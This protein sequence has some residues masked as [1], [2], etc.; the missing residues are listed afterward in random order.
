MLAIAQEWLI[1]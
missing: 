1:R